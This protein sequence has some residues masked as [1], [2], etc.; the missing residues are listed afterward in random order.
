MSYFVYI[1]SN[2]K[3]NPLY[4]GVTNNLERRIFEHKNKLIPDSFSSRYFLDKLL[5]WEITEDV[6]SAI[7]REKQLKDWHKDWKLNL[8]KSTNPKY[9]DLSILPNYC[10]CDES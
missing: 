5:Y 2:Q 8:I 9:K 4:T 7:S 3:N 1:I 10:D 6:I